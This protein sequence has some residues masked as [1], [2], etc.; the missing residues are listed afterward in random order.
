MNV[1]NYNNLSFCKA[2]IAELEAIKYFYGL[3]M[4]TESLLMLQKYFYTVE[5]R[6]PTSDEL[7]LIDSFHKLNAKSASSVLVKALRS[8]DKNAGDAFDDI[9]AK[10]E[11]LENKRREAY[12]YADL[13]GTSQKVLDYCR[14]NVN[15]NRLNV[16]CS[17]FPLACAMNDPKAK[18]HITVSFN[19]FNFALSERHP[20]TLDENAYRSCDTDHFVLLCKAEQNE[21]SLECAILKLKLALGSTA[22]IKKIT[23]TGQ[24]GIVGAALSSAEG[25]FLN[26]SMLLPLPYSFSPRNLRAGLPEECALATESDTGISN[27]VSSAE[28]FGIKAIPFGRPTKV[29]RLTLISG[30]GIPLSLSSDLLRNIAS[31]QTVCAEILQDGSAKYADD[32]DALH[33]E[34]KIICTAALE[35]GGFSGAAKT[36]IY[37]LSKLV[38]CGVPPKKAISSVGISAKDRSAGE[39]LAYIAGVYRVRSELSLAS[40]ND[41]ILDNS[42][43]PLCSLVTATKSNAQEI[44]HSFTGESGNVYLLYPRSSDDSLPKFS[45]LRCLFE[46]VI[47]LIESKKIMSI[48]AVGAHAC[49]TLDFNLRRCK[50]V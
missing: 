31:N 45:D 41:C 30:S 28:K 15:Q 39:I 33:I 42:A 37:S 47:S 7:A 40:G 26:L 11:K 38:A 19:G 48:R 20:D 44:P 18:N 35:S 13:L 5:L 22:V 17:D 14:S 12:S 21:S 43:L 36:L 46:Y 1:N 23:M 9:I 4:D 3:Q 2:S 24:S 25:A 29:K 10:L 8:T 49:S 6:E 32:T 34:D 50:G 16:Y 27:I